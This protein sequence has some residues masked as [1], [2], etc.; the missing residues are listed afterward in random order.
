M[1]LYKCVVINSKGIRHVIKME[2]FSE[3]NILDNLKDNNFVVVTVKCIISSFSQIENIRLIKK[4]KSNDLSMFCKQTSAMLKSGITIERCLEIL[5]VQSDSK[6]FRWILSHMYRELLTG[7]TFSESIDNHKGSFPVIFAAMVKSGEISGNIDV[8]MESLANHYCKENKI[9][10]KIKSALAYPAILSFVS[11]I[12]VVFLLIKVMPTFVGL[13]QS[14]GV[15]LPFITE[16]LLDISQWLKSYWYILLLVLATIVFAFSKLNNNVNIR[17]KIDRFK[18]RIPIYGKFFSKLAASRF[19]RT[20]STLLVNGIS[21]LESMD[22][23]SLV[24]GNSYIAKLILNVR[25]DVKTG[26]PLSFSL[27]SIGLFPPMV[28]TM[29]KIGEE[30]GNVEELLERTADFYDDEMDNAVQRMVSMIEP[31]MIVFMAVIIG[32][33]MLAMLMPMFDMVNTIQ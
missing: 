26:S 8:V 11:I 15:P 33:I 14:S 1:G 18:M 7:V 4:I 24:I 2:G 6:Y 13:Y 17:F 21:L 28:H 10:N 5:S 27:G 25:E 31:V 22:T 3:E 20:L 32:F 19:S 29:I 30:S 12:V 23:V 9:E 16:I